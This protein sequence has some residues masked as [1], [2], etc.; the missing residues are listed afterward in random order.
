MRILNLLFKSLLVVGVLISTAESRSKRVS[1]LPNGSSF[2]CAKCH[3]DAGGGGTRTSFGEVVR[4]TFLDANGDVIWNQALASNDADGDGVSNGAEL[5]DPNGTWVKGTSNPGT[6]AL[7]SNPGDPNS[8]TN[9]E[10]VNGVS[11]P[12]SF[13]LDQ[14]YPNPFN[15]TT[16]IYFNVAKAGEIQIRIFNSMGQVVRTLAHSSFQ[17]GRYKVQW[18]GLDDFGQSL[19]SGLYIYRLDAEEFNQTRRMTFLK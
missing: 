16:T 7:V 5:L 9:V 19:S 11:I 15:P 4:T 8:T 2:G 13:S 18:N 10:M 3:V 1:Q 14:N 17:P 6:P 12:E